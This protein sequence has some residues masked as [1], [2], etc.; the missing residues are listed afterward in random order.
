MP[1]LCDIGSMIWSKPGMNGGRPCIAG[2]G[3]SVRCIAVYDMKSYLAEEIVADRPYLTLAQ[4]H[5]ARAYYWASKDEI[6]AD[7]AAEAA[8]YDE[9]SKGKPK[10]P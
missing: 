5:A 7:L 9:M 2:T 8:F 3:T 4:V 1:V 10:R 6:D